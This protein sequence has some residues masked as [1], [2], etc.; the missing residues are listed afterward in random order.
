MQETSST[1][2]PLAIYDELL[3]LGEAPDAAAFCRLYP[4]SP[5]LAGRIAQLTQLRHD[6][7]RLAIQQRQ[8]FTPRE[9][10]V[11]GF[12]LQRVL[13]Q[14]GM[15]VVYLARQHHPDRRCAIKFID[16]RL[17]FAEDRFRREADLAGR[18]AHPNI[19]NVYASGVVGDQPYM[20]SEFVAGFSLKSLLSVADVMPRNVHGDWLVLALRALAE[21]YAGGENPI[22]YAPNR[23][24]VRIAQ[25]IAEALGHA[26]AQGVM[27]RDVKPSNIIIGFD[28]SAK[29]I[30]FGIAVPIDAPHE[31]VTGTGM[32]VGSWAYAAPEQ[33]RGQLELLGSWTDTY[34]LG[35]T[36]YE[37]L[38]QQTPFSFL[39]V[40]QR[41]VRLDELPPRPSAL[42]SEVPADLEDI[43]MRAL[44]PDPQK[45]FLDGDEMAEILGEWLRN[46]RPLWSR[47]V[48]RWSSLLR[49]KIRT[50]AL[51]LLAMILFCMFCFAL[52]VREQR[53]NTF[54]TAQLQAQQMFTARALL[55]GTLRERKVQVQNCL[56]DF[57][58][59]TEIS[60]DITVFPNGTVLAEWPGGLHSSTKTCLQ[61]ILEQVPTAGIGAK[62]P[63][64]LRVRLDPRANE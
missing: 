21:G 7:D 8:I 26:H 18:L 23:V 24:M 49:I 50:G 4:Q 13:G 43:V 29:L 38:T 54:L 27:H 64:T 28:E 15:G 35:A 10:S 3:Q 1:T 40:D 33:M 17:P 9:L 63:V 22:L 6:L 39:E 31:H 36:L 55:D 57:A 30:D 25:Q 20:V 53:R 2:D 44:H 46:K 62:W 56:S 5:S 32:F 45:R 41:L 14:G 60:A 16:A 34:Q 61:Q 59:V 19:A 37:L 58:H 12:T 11:P 52:V 42:N 47:H 48:S 51:F